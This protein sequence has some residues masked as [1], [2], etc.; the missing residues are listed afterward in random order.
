[1]RFEPFLLEDWLIECLGASIDLDHSGAPD[2]SGEGFSPSVDESDL[3]EFE[4]EDRLYKA[5][6]SAYKVRRS[7]IALTFGAQ[8]ANYAFF[9]SCFSRKDR[10]MV[11][12]PTYA[13]MRACAHALFSSCTSVPRPRADGYRLD[14]SSLE[15]GLRKGAKVLSLTNLH[16]PSARML[17]DDDMKA[18]LE[19]SSSKGALVLVDEVYR[20]MCHSRPPKAAFQLGENGVTTNG[21]SKLWGLGKLRA[22]WLIGP[23]EVAKK[24]NETRLYSSWHLPTRSMALA[25]EALKRREWFR[26]RVLAIARRNLPVIRDWAVGEKR[27]RITDPQGC[28]HLLVHLPEGVDD[29][30]FARKLLRKHGTAVCPGRYFGEEGSVRIT[31]SCGAEHL[32]T[33]LG[34]MSDV[35][36]GL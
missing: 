16:N 32:E 3:S 34:Q 17:D 24:V 28:L 21:L 31:Y 33:G 12:A 22:G 9:D 2:P 15:K 1:M 14:M 30:S 13:P 20:E 36:D 29:E 25:V 23:E 11:E 26:Q 10:A 27:V 7:R 19:A 8:S 35:L 18:I 6:S 5:I 4:A